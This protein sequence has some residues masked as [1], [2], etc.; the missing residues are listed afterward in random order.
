MLMGCVALND[1]FGKNFSLNSVAGFPS[2]LPELEKI[3]YFCE[4]CLRERNCKSEYID[5]CNTVTI[6]T[7]NEALARAVERANVEA[8]YFLINVAKADVNSVTG[9]YQETPLIIASYY[10]TKVHQEIADFLLSH[11]AHMDDTGLD[12]KTA[13]MTAIWKNNTDFAEKGA[14]PSS[15]PRGDIDGL[16]CRY[17]AKKIFLAYCHQFLLAVLYF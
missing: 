1:M 12:S 10:G 15:T 7:R 16:A 8:V 4:K 6:P 9:R 3:W 5:Q 14:N 17:A 13:L 2:D 11:G